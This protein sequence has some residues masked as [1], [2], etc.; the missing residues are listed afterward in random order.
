MR[1]GVDGNPIVDDVRPSEPGS[2]AG[3]LERALA[4]RRIGR[5]RPRR[6]HAPVDELA[7]PG[8]RRL[9][10]R[11]EPGFRAPRRSVSD[12]RRAV[13]VGAALA[14]DARS[15]AKRALVRP[16]RLVALAVERLRP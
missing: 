10:D 9:L 7:R 4:E 8:E 15:P 6:G 13:D 12:V 1:V 2:R 11:A 3:Q 16:L 5:A 14:E